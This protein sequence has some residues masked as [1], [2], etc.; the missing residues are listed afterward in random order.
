MARNMPPTIVQQSTIAAG[1]GTWDVPD[2]SHYKNFLIQTKGATF[3]GSYAV[4]IT[5]GYQNNW[6][7]CATGAFP[8]PPDNDVL[9]EIEPMTP[10][11]VGGLRVVILGTTAPTQ[12]A[13]V[14]TTAPASIKRDG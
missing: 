14:M 9:L 1:G 7:T 12:V 2:S 13:V 5:T 8:V 6:I 4:Q 3:K 11:Y 10:P